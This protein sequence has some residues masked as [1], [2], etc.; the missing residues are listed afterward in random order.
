VAASAQRPEAVE[1]L[2]QLSPSDSLTVM[3][4][5]AEHVL[6]WVP[7]LG[8][9][10]WRLAQ[11]IWPAPLVLLCPEGWSDGLA[12]QLAEPVR[13][14]LGAS[15]A[16]ALSVPDEPGLWYTLLLAA[17]PVVLA[18]RPADCG[19]A[20]ALRIEAGEARPATV[21]RSHADRWELVREGAVT[22]AE[23]DATTRRRVLFVCTGNTCRSPMAAALF[24]KLLAERLGCA[25]TE[26][27][28]RGY[29]IGSA[30]IAAYPGEPAAPE[31]IEA[32]R[33]LGADL[34]GHAS[35]PLTPDQA[36]QADFLITMTRGHQGAIA[37]LFD[38]VVEPRT[39]C[40]QGSD[41]ADPIGAGPEVYRH[42]AR[43][44]LAH[45]EHWIAELER[46][47]A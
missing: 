19:D 31:A 22:R 35:Q 33:E 25:V 40:P 17:C 16:I 7:G 29:E 18:P 27:E 39:L 26:L 10:A 43:Q 45:L 32:V 38:Q 5:S 9:A 8:Q 44:I 12:T 21:V 1:R 3:L 2:R 24:R 34:A 37:S 23:L 6:R 13:G 41:V 36:R 15:G 14:L 28:Q 46:P 4:P 11:R 42:C 30:G 20:V 47:C